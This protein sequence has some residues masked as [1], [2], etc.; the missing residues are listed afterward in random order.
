MSKRNNNLFGKPEKKSK[1]VQII[2]QQKEF[3][4]I[5]GFKYMKTVRKKIYHAASQETRDNVKNMG[6]REKNWQEKLSSA[7]LVGS[8]YIEAPRVPKKPDFYWKDG[9]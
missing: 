6:K 4:D 1:L 2:T 7:T 9:K 5:N 8:H 3:T